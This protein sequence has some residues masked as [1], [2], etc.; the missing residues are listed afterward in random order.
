MKA[1]S[2]VSAVAYRLGGGVARREDGRAR[3][4]MF[5]GTPRRLAGRLEG[6]LRYLKRHFH[7]VPLG[8]LVRDP[9]LRRCVALTF[10]DGLRSNVEV[11]WPMLERLGLPATF[12]VCPGLV[13]EGR[14][15]WTHEV[16]ARLG[17]MAVADAQAEAQVRA[18]KA[19][20]LGERLDAEAKLREATPHWTPSAEEKEDHDLARWP[21]LRALDPAL[22][23]VGSHTLTHAILTKLDAARMEHEVAASR[24]LLE[25]RL[26]R[27]APAF[28]YPNGDVDAAVH[29]CVARHYACAVTAHE[30]FVEPGGDPH[31]L[32]RVNAHWNLLRLVL[33][34]HREHRQDYFFVTPSTASGSQVAT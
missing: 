12:F 24:S 17:S 3:I 26:Q 5:H 34:L 20:P 19:L 4:L 22:V 13:D 30:G 29:E 14:W 6:I 15:L 28:A 9:D 27:P 31:L 2:L 11:A 18:M 33:A 8:T 32:R 1:T 7:V 23:S 16:R 21:E 10:D 25:E